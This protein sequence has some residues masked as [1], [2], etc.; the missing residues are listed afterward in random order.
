MR[1][2]TALTVVEPYRTDEMQLIDNATGN[3]T[4]TE[5]NQFEAIEAVPQFAANWARLSHMQND[6]RSVLTA[7]VNASGA[8]PIGATSLCGQYCFAHKSWS[9]STSPREDAPQKYLRDAKK[10]GEMDRNVGIFMSYDT[11]PFPG[12]K[13]CTISRGLLRAMIKMPPAA[14]LVHSHTAHIGHPEVVDL[15][16][17]LSQATNVIAGI[18][19][20]TDSDDTG[21][22]RP[23]H[24]SVQDRVEAIVRLAKKGVKTQASTTPLLGYLDYKTFVRRFRDEGVYRVMIGELRKEFAGG[25]TARAIG[26]ELGLP[27]P[28]E[29]EAGAYCAELRFPGGVDVR[30]KFYVT[31]S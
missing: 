1:T 7:T 16:G 15:L 26:M 24:H 5:P 17:E 28:T 23:H 25:G 10:L 12:G 27:A 3:F 9:A 30:E 21:H 14:L 22:N 11:E 13:I 4:S 2:S 18:G 8:C 31:M 20:E 19:F 29:E 6:A